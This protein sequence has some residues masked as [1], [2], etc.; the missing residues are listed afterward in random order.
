MARDPGFGV[1]RFM[2]TP[3]HERNDVQAVAYVMN[4][5]LKRLKST[6]PTHVLPHLAKAAIRELERRGWENL[7]KRPK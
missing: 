7:C 2:E 3:A 4:R 6:R 5:M 1:T